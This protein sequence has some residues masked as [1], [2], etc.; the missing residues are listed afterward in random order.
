[1]PALVQSLFLLACCAGKPVVAFIRAF[2]SYRACEACALPIV[3]QEALFRVCFAGDP[4]KFANNAM[5]GQIK[6]ST[7]RSAA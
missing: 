5:T 2:A 4:A 1:M 6:I 7:V 3:R